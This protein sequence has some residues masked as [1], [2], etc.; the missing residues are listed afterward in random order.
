MA[1][2]RT[3]LISFLFSRHSWFFPF[4]QRQPT[5]KSLFKIKRRRWK[6]PNIYHKALFK[7][8]YASCLLLCNKRKFTCPPSVQQV[9]PG[10]E[11]CLFRT[12]LLCSKRT[13]FSKTWQASEN[14]SWV[15]VARVQPIDVSRAQEHHVKNGRCTRRSCNKSRRSIAQWNISSTIPNLST[16]D[17]F[18]VTF[19]WFQRWKVSIKKL[20]HSGKLEKKPKGDVVSRRGRQHSRC[21]ICIDWTLG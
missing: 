11:D 10:E 15:I 18:K 17:I 6:K 20:L 2:L 7:I 8:K 14:P 16:K 3:I 19:N 21:Q 12:Q 13:S 5:T 4:F 9:L 1:I